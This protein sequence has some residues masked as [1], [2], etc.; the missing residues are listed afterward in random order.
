[1][2]QLFDLAVLGGGPGGYVAAIRAGQLGLKTVLIEADLMGGT[3]LNRGCIPTKSLLH[4]AEVYQNAVH[5]EDFGINTGE[6]SF[7]YARIAA[8]KDKVVD[9]LRRGVNQLVKSNGGTI[10]HGYGTIIDARTI[11]VS[12]K[13]AGTV[14]ANKIIIATGSKPFIPPIPGV[15]SSRVLDSTK[16]LALTECP[17][18]LTIIGGGVI[19]MEFASLFQQLNVPVTVLEM[20]PE[21]LPEVDV[22]VARILRKSLQRQ[23]ATIFTSAKVTAI[24]SGEHNATCSF[25]L[26]G[27]TKTVTSELVLIAIG[28]RPQS[29]DIGLTNIGIETVKGAIP[30]NEQM[31]TKVPGVYAVGDVTGKIML[32]HVASEQGTVAAENAAGGKARM[33]YNIVPNC[34]Y[35]YPEIACIGISEEKA[36]S[37]GIATKV[38]RFPVAANGKAMLANDTEGICKLVSDAATGELLGAQIIGPKATE[39]IS[40]LGVSMTLETTIAE[41]GATI[42]PH[43]TVSEMIAEAA[44]DTTNRALHYFRRQPKQE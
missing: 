11:S 19:G 29:A 14:K 32:A 2:E 9:Q 22:E 27:E 23:G 44:L 40:G 28:R 25:E 8:R 20:M 41:I 37:Q 16:L 34:I 42:H 18:S 6:V 12:G 26:A 33:K 3:C 30:V 36:K 10:L 13:D 43:P 31:E 17:A 39:L 4:A 15:D 38:G 35:T 5:S 21:I 1:M 24:E 7:D